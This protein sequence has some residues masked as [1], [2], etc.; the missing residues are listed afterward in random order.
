M[1]TTAQT[2]ISASI[3]QLRMKSLFF[4]AIRK[5]NDRQNAGLAIYLTDGYGDF[6]ASHPE[7]PT[8]WV[9]TAGELHLDQFLFTATVRSLTDR[10]IAKQSANRALVLKP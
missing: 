2:L 3:L 4:D 8:L 6:P 5:A 10:T 7:I 1:T 9:V